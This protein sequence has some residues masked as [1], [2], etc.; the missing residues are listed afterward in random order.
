MYS[1]RAQKL[2]VSEIHLPVEKLEEF[3]QSSIFSQID[4]SL[5][6]ILAAKHFLPGNSQRTPPVVPLPPSFNGRHLPRIGVVANLLR[7]VPLPASTRAQYLPS[8][9]PRLRY[10]FLFLISGDRDNF[11]HFFFFLSL[12]FHVAEPEG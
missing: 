8:Q 10:N 3:N 6:N 7:I 9:R 2:P 5:L 12:D 1:I 4:F 11:G